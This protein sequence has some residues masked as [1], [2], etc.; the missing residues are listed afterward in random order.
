MFDHST[1]QDT[2][3]GHGRAQVPDGYGTFHRPIARVLF[4]L[5]SIGGTS[6]CSSTR[7]LKWGLGANK[8]AD[9]NAN[10]RRVRFPA[11]LPKITSPPLERSRLPRRSGT[12]TGA[13]PMKLPLGFRNGILQLRSG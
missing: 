13:S 7:R 4:L 1:D 12:N 6:R 3:R 5:E 9:E 10:I 8:A 2:G 11:E